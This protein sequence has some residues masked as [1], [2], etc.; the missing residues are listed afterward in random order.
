MAKYKHILLIALCIFLSATS[1]AW[2]TNLEITGEWVSAE[3]YGHIEGKGFQS[4]DSATL[5]I[6]VQQGRAFSGTLNL[7]TQDS[8]QTVAVSGVIDFGDDGFYLVKSGE[9]NSDSSFFSGRILSRDEIALTALTTG[10]NKAAMTYRL[11]RQG[12]TDNYMSGSVGYVHFFVVPSLV[13]GVNHIAGQI[14]DL[15]KMLIKIAG[16][17]TE[18]GLSHG[19]AVKKDGNIELENNFSFV[20]TSKTDISQELASFI[21]QRFKSKHPFIVTW[22]A[23]ISI[24]NAL[25]SRMQNKN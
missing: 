16:G 8:E 18:L 12:L 15:K 14:T 17:Y 6:D 3:S 13:P 5:K 24:Y 10:K 20:V 21:K 23:N 2:A 19:G 4:T 22:P 9:E 25:D 1:A 11:V 7:G